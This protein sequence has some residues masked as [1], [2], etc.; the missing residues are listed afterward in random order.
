MSRGASWPTL[1]VERRLRQEVGAEDRGQDED[2]D[3]G[4]DG[5][6]RRRHGA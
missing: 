5:E 4:R 1:T 6:P 2:E 3:P